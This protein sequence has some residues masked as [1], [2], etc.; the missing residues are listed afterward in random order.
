MSATTVEEPTT[1]H[2]Q[3]EAL[4]ELENV[5]KSYGN[6][7]ALRGVNISVRQGEVTCVLGD[8]GAGKSTLIKIVAGLHD[9]T[10]GSMKLN[11][12]VRRF[13][14]PRA[15]QAA[16]IAT[17]YQDLALAPLMSVWRNFFL[18]NEMRSGLGLDID[19]MKSICDAELTKMGIAIPDLDRPVGGLSGGQRQC[20]AIARAIY[21]GA[22]VIILDEPTA[23]LGVKQ[24]GVV[25]KYIVAARDAGLG[26]IF[27]THNPHHAYLVGNHFVILKLGRVVLDA[28]RDELTLNQLTG[29]MAGGQ[30]LEELSHELGGI[31][32]GK[33]VDVEQGERVHVTTP[34][35]DAEEIAEVQAEEAGEEK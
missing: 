30:E 13:G 9:Y 14:S 20:I 2:A 16:G 31:D 23:A 15:A 12:I 33:V 25:L 6:V 29:E 22:R 8:N 28:H 10:E 35:L 32:P 5:G 24:S 4:L 21:F 11:G 7:H 26:V 27:I 17:V 3:G 1:T 34:V 18:G 19:K